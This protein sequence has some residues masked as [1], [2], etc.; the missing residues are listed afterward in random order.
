MSPA[1]TSDSTAAPESTDELVGAA[2]TELVTI[3]VG[4]VTV[5]SDGDDPGPLLCCQRR[6]RPEQL[7]RD[8]WPGRFDEHADHRRCAASRP[9]IGDGLRV[10]RLVR[11]ATFTRM[12]QHSGLIEQA[13]GLANLLADRTLE[14]HC[15]PA[16]VVD[17]Q[18][19]D[20]RRAALLPPRAFAQ[21]RRADALE[22]ARVH[23]GATLGRNLG[24]IAQPLGA[25]QHGRQRGARLDQPVVLLAGRR[26]WL[27]SISSTL[28][29]PRNGR[30][31]SSATHGPTWP[32]S[33]S[34][35]LRPDRMRSNGPERSSAA[36]SARAV[37][38]VSLPANAGSVI[39]HAAISSPGDGLAQRVLG[40]RRPECED[41][42]GAAGL[43]GQLDALADGAPAVGVHLEVEPVATQ[44][45]A[46]AEL[47]LLDPRNLLDQDG[48]AQSQERP[49][50]SN[51]RLSK[52]NLGYRLR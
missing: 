18:F 38:S 13:D 52:T 42:A 2:P 14:P 20:G 25:R 3:E 1:A 29:P 10:V 37:A 32:V 50:C 16:V 43:A 26:D 33:A 30:S 35:E 7:P 15:T 49:L 11:P 12:T 41:R 27:P 31:S 28:T 21:V 6:G 48:N 34:T 8:P 45:S 39:E 19:A 17:P 24:R 4:G 46:R 40:R 44:H 22:A 23:G 5:E 51:E 47:H 9:A 36:T